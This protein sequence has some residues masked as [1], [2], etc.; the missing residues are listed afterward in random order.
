MAGPV[1]LPHQIFLMTSI[2]YIKL[3][4][5]QKGFMSSREHWSGVAPTNVPWI[6]SALNAL[7]II[8]VVDAPSL[9]KR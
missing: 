9:G 6:L 7:E 3:T 4:V 8:L 2:S 1:I 5:F